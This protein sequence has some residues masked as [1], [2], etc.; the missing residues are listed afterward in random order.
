M[1]ARPE[2]VEPAAAA[3]FEPEPELEPEPEPAE[4]EPEPEPEPQPQPQPQPAIDAL[5][6][7]QDD[8]DE[9]SHVIELPTFHVS[10]HPGHWGIVLE[11][12]WSFMASFPHGAVEDVRSEEPSYL[13]MTVGAQWGEIEVSVQAATP[14]ATW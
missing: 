9:Y 1:Q 7:A 14:I 6:P 10:R 8:E 11:N 3:N 2:Q 4:P 13:R 12:C 5:E